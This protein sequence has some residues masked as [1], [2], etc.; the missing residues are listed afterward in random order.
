MT[1]KGNNIDDPGVGIE[2]DKIKVPK[3]DSAP[4]SQE[5][6]TSK[7][8]ITEKPGKIELEAESEIVLPKKS[9]LKVIMAVAA[10]ILAAALF[11]L[12]N[13]KI[14]K[15]PFLA[16]KGKDSA[17]ASPAY[18]TIAPIITNL[19]E[20]RRIQ[21]SLMIKY[22]PEL[23]QKISAVDPIIRDDILMLLTSADVKRMTKESDL[24]K[25]KSYIENK[26][27]SLL[28]SNYNDK[29]ILKELKVY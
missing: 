14:I 25:L 28:K 8:S 27:K 16:R 23:A 6:G 20:K 12:W 22:D 11:F 24:E 15:L 7:A 10:I 3:T 18:H 29:I 4:G 9:R 17:K 1:E 26:L 19:G 2:L 13:Q 5:P 21:I